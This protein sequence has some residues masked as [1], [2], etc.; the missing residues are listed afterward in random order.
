[1]TDRRFPPPWSVDDPETKLGQ[2][3]FIVRDANGHALAYVYFEDEPG[4]RSAAYLMT[5][6]EAHRGEHCEAAGVIAK[7]IFY[8]D[9]KSARGPARFGAHFPAGSLG[10]LQPKLR[11]IEYSRD[12]LQGRAILHHVETCRSKAAVLFPNYIHSAPFRVIVGPSERQK[13]D[14]RTFQELT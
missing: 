2:T 12:V 4:R 14:R 9:R 3:C 11:N 8:L 5:R 7:A 1:M 13:E 6:D 10:Q